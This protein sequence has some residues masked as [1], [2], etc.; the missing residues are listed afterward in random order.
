MNRSESVS[1]TSAEESL[2]ATRADPRF[3]SRG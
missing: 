3:M 1:M 2:R